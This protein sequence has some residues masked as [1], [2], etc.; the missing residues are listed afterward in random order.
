MTALHSKAMHIL[1]LLSL[2]IMSASPI[3]AE[4]TPTDSLLA[5]SETQSQKSELP[6]VLIKTNLGDITLEL[7]SEKAPISVNNFLTYV[8]EG[9]YDDLIFHRVIAGFMIQGGGFNKSMEK[10]TTK[11]PIKNEAMNRIRNT[12]GTIA[13]ARTNAV[14]SATSQFFINLEDNNNLDNSSQSFGYA[15][16]GQVIKGMDV[17]DQIAASQVKRIGMH[18]HMPSPAI[19][20]ESATHIN[21]VEPAE[22]MPATEPNEI[23]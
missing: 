13:M 15:V 7:F 8:N 22:G 16:F 11:A 17:V 21:K 5:T 2:F 1:L 14:D 9:F 19:Y 18:Q 23:E 12:R 3:H 4:A 10:K 20:I 6:Q